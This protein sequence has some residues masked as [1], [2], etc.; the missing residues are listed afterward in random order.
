MITFPKL[1]A[2]VMQMRCV[3]GGVRTEFLNVFFLFRRVRT[4]HRL[5]VFRNRLFRRI[6]RAETEEVTGTGDTCRMDSFVIRRAQLKPDGT[7]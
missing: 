4:G 7:R 3:F 2:F 6:F 5:G 1:L